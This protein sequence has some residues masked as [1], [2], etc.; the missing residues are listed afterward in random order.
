MASFVSARY[1]NYM[2]F[3]SSLRK[4]EKYLI[5]N[6]RVPIAITLERFK[7]FIKWPIENLTEAE[8]KMNFCDQRAESMA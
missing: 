7:C 1:A 3:I 2:N 4:I 8:C 5:S 6:N